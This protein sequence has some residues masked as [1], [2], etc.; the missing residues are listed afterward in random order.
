[1]TFD[2]FLQV[3]ERFTLIP[4]L[5]G[6]KII[7]A[8]MQNGNE[9]HV[10][11]SQKPKTSHRGDLRRIM[12]PLLEQYGEIKTGVRNDNQK[13]LAI[14]KRLGFVENRRDE[15]GIHLICKEMRHA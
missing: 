2:Q 7:G 13:G 14:C 10:G 11:F 9:I 15:A 4:I 6:G 3:I 12:K 8:V 5:E 1:M